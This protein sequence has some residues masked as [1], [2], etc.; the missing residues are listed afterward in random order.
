MKPAINTAPF[1]GVRLNSA[2]VYDK[3]TARTY[4]PKHQ[5]DPR[6][7]NGRAEWPAYIGAVSNASNKRHSAS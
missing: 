4:D 6:L 7:D 3:Y 2:Q 1:R 5:D